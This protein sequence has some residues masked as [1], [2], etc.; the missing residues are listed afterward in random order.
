MK[1]VSVRDFQLK[2]YEC[3]KELPIMLTRYG[4]DI[5][6]IKRASQE[7]KPEIKEH[8]DLSEPKKDIKP[9]LSETKKEGYHFNSMLGKYIKD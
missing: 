6:I 1:K 2:P 9:M 8:L 7:V 3:L 4:E 5:A